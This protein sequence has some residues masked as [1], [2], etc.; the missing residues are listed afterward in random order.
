MGNL[1]FKKQNKMTENLTN[2]IGEKKSIGCSQE[3][4]DR[5]YSATANVEEKAGSGF[6]SYIE[7]RIP[8]VKDFCLA[9]AEIISFPIVY[10][11][12]W[13]VNQYKKI[14]V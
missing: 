7:K 2:K 1:I 4:K 3:K 14:V 8:T 6:I 5:G 13:Y 11:G 9:L 10:A 12:E